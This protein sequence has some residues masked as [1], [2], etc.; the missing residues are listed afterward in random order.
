MKKFI[1]PVSVAVALL[2]GLLVGFVVGRALLERQWSAPVTLLTAPEAQK[3][4]AV[5]GS[6]PVPE[7]NSQVLGALPLI[8]MREA[9]AKLTAND[10]VQVTLTS[11]GSGDDGSELHLMLQNNAACVLKSVRGV[12]YAYDS[13]GMPV[14]ANAGG[15]VFVGFASKV[16]ASLHI[17]P[18]KKHVFAQPLHHTETASLG[19]AHVDAYTCEDGKTWT[20]PK[21]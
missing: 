8:K 21:S 3:L 6:D 13:S 4:A 2:V 1:L 17:E 12:A 10:P 5:Q 7:A 11:F 19:V 15:S 20:R 16:D 14:Q 18:K 9:T